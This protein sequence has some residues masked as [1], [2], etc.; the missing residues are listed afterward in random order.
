MPNHHPL[1]HHDLLQQEVARLKRDL[2]AARAETQ[3]AHVLLN[4]ARAGNAK[5]IHALDCAIIWAE[6]LFAWLP[7]GTVMS[8]GI[9]AAKNNLSRALQEVR[10]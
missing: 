3:A 5:L 2:M 10:K 1:E 6:A 9:E 4:E 7:P 8:P